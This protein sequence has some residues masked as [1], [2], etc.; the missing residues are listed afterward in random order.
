MF[1]PRGRNF[2]SQLDHELESTALKRNEIRCGKIK[3]TCLASQKLSMTSNHGPQDH[4]N[5]DLN[6]TNGEANLLSA[7]H[8]QEGCLQKT[9]F[10]QASSLFRGCRWEIRALSVALFSVEETESHVVVAGLLLLLLLGRGLASG[11]GGFRGGGRG[12]GSGADAGR[13]VGDELLDVAA[14]Q[15]L[16]E[17]AGPVRLHL[18]LGGLEKGRDLL[19]LKRESQGL[20]GVVSD[21]DSVLTVIATSSSARMSAA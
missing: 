16:G 10:H 6:Q 13:D 20:N 18:Q 5:A 15:G 2:P 14:L 8:S 12:C 4:E 11:C 19:S 1:G 7:T 3:D 9:L 17:E 21:F